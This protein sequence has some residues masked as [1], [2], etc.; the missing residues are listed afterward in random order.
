MAIYPWN[1][2]TCLTSFGRME[3]ELYK[4]HIVHCIELSLTAVFLFNCVFTLFFEINPA[5]CRALHM[6]TWLR[7]DENYTTY[8]HTLFWTLVTGSLMMLLLIMVMSTNRDIEMVKNYRRNSGGTLWQKFNLIDIWHLKFDIRHLTL[9]IQS[10]S[11]RILWHQ[12]H[13]HCLS[14]LE[15]HL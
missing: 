7:R 5:W 2:R 12:L 15:W 14:D 13:W 10:A 9:D 4:E 3:N 6:P 8:Y 1:F 11:I